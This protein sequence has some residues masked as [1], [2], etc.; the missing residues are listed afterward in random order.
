MILFAA[1]STPADCSQNCYR[2]IAAAVLSCFASVENMASVLSYHYEHSAD[3]LW[4]TVA[5]KILSEFSSLI[6]YT[7]SQKKRPN[8]AT[9]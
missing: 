8:F 2:S 5:R 6:I 3:H 9:V 7:V 4:F 1:A